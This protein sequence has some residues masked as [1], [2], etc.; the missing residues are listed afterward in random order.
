MKDRRIRHGVYPDHSGPFLLYMKDRRIRH[1][2][3]PGH[4]GP[5]LLS[6]AEAFLTNEAL[7]ELVAK[8]DFHPPQI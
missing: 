7:A 5:F 1:G 3:Y 4:S 8:A 2:V 6:S